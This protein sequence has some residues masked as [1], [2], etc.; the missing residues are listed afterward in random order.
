MAKEVEE[1]RD[2]EE[3]REKVEGGAKGEPNGSNSRYDGRKKP[4]ELPPFQ[5]LFLVLK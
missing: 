2:G 4:H 1:G 5:L 3:I